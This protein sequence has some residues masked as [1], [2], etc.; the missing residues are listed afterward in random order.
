MLNEYYPTD[1]SQKKLFKKCD[2]SEEKMMN[3]IITKRSGVG[4]KKKGD[5]KKDSNG[6]LFFKGLSP[7]ILLPFICLI[8]ITLVMYFVSVDGYGWIL[9]SSILGTSVKYLQIG[10]YVA[11]VVLY[12][13]V[14]G[15][16][17]IMGNKKDINEKIVA[18]KAFS[19]AVIMFLLPCIGMSL[20]MRLIG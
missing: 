2:K 16:S 17:A 20:F 1:K 7:S 10:F 5:R 11:T 4:Y 8:L 18:S 12:S 13:I 15:V 3:E 19:A 6:R 14:Y 9:F